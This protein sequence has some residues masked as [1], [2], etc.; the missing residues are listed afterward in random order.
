MRFRLLLTLARILLTFSV[1][2]LHRHLHIP[3]PFQRSYVFTH[4][5]YLLLQWLFSSPFPSIPPGSNPLT[6]FRGLGLRRVQWAAGSRNT[7]SVNAALRL[8]FQM[9][10]SDQQWERP[11]AKDRGKVEGVELPEFVQGQWREREEGIGLGRHSALLSMGWDRWEKEGRAK[12][13]RM[14]AERGVARR[15]AKDVL[16]DLL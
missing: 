14:A 16:G 13:E 15:N 2:P 6:T 8:G 12:L 1:F 11:L 10:A 4:A 5:A 7:A 3:A 9:E